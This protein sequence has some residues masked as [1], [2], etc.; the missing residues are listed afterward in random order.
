MQTRRRRSTEEWTEILEEFEQSRLGFSAFAR[1]YGVG[2]NSLRRWHARLWVERA[3]S[4]EIALVPVDV[5]G[6]PRDDR[7][8]V[9][10]VGSVEVRVPVGAD[11]AYVAALARELGRC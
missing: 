9:V 5:V 1:S 3:P 2:E 6:T 11:V 8:L 7:A 10:V 4:P